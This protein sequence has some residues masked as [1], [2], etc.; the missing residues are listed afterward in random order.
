[1][2]F[3]ISLLYAGVHIGDVICSLRVARMASVAADAD[4]SESEISFGIVMFG[5]CSSYSPIS[6]MYR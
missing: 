4:L 6:A 3:L 5:R 1:M 2:V